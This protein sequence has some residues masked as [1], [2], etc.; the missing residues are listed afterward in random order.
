MNP[1]KQPQP[2]MEKEHQLQDSLMELAP[3]RM[4]SHTTK[5]G[6]MLMLTGSMRKNSSRNNKVTV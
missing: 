1:K 2:V 6:L 3:G 4:W 5:S